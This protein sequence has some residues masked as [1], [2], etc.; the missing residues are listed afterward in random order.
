VG[1]FARAEG[2]SFDNILDDLFT[3]DFTL[4]ISSWPLLPDPD[5]RLFWRSTENSEGFG[6]NF[7]SFNSP[8]LD[9][10]MDRAVAMPGCDSQSRARIYADIQAILAQERPVDFLVG[11]QRR[12]LVAKRLQGLTAGPFAP[13]TW[14]AVHWY[15]QE[16]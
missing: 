6:L 8:E 11:S 10:L 12:L 14:N 7:T 5:Q 9:K 2:V 4:A 1:L 15:V 16:N 13:F 3:H